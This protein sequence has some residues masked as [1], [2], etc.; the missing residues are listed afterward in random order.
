M[1]AFYDFNTGRQIP[2]SSARQ[3][4]NPAYREAVTN[5]PACAPS[6]GEVSQDDYLKLAMDGH[7]GA[8]LC[9]AA[10]DIIA[11]IR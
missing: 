7:P 11:S 5:S 4:L 1:T 2:E 10:L 3:K 9:V 8:P 6:F